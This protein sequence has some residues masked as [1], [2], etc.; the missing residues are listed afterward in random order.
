[1]KLSVLDRLVVQGILPERTNYLNLKLLRIAR[2]KLSFDDKET[3][4][5]NL[6]QDGEKVVWD[7][8][9]PEKDIDLGKVVTEMVAEGLKKLDADEELTNDHVAIY[10][11]FVEGEE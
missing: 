2:E 7:S 6:H 5:L 9:V 8:T 1:M 4:E 11:K 10:K 3:K